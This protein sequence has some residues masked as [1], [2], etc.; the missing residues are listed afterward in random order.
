MFSVFENICFIR[1]HHWRASHLI[2]PWFQTNQAELYDLWPSG[3]QRQLLRCSACPCPISS[4]MLTESFYLPGDNMIVTCSSLVLVLCHGFT[5]QHM[6]SS[7][8]E[9]SIQ[10]EVGFGSIVFGGTLFFFFFETT[11][12]EGCLHVF[13]CIALCLQ[14]QAKETY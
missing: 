3:A 13:F 2:C 5:R 8:S 9:H 4:T 12:T 7:G 14:V 6:I 10:R 11:K 1:H